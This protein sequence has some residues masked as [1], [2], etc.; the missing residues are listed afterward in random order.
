MPIE[1][2]QTPVG[3]QYEL[4]WEEFED[5][6]DRAR[7]FESRD[8]A[9]RYEATVKQVLAEYDGNAG[10]EFDAESPLAWEQLESCLIDLIE[11][12]W[13]GLLISETS[14]LPKPVGSLEWTAMTEGELHAKRAS[15]PQPKSEP[16]V[17]KPTLMRDPDDPDTRRM[18]LLLQ[19][20]GMAEA[21]DEP[22]DR[23][24]LAGQLEGGALTVRLELEQLDHKGLIWL[25]VDDIDDMVRLRDSGRQWLATKREWSQDILFFLPLYIDDLYAREALIVAG[26]VMV[27]E[28]RYQL[29]HHGGAVDYVRTWVVPH[30]FEQAVDESLALNLYSAAVALMARLSD[31]EPAGCVAEE[32]MAVH[33]IN[34]AASLLESAAIDEGGPLTAITA[35]EATRATGELNGIF[36]LFED[37]DVKALF[38]MKE[39]ADARRCGAQSDQ[40]CARSRGPAPAGVVPAVRPRHRDGLPARGL[41]DGLTRPRLESRRDLVR[42]R[43]R[44]VSDG[45]GSPRFAGSPSTHYA[46]TSRLR[47]C[48][49]ALAYPAAVDRPWTAGDAAS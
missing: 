24:A 11:T 4:T 44:T 20:V 40:P 8:K 19:A 31:E 38:D 32:I 10:S 33:L 35:E 42:G 9:E 41:L 15:K 46:A 25:D 49:G 28:F 29:L 39:P 2:V 18:T 13:P 30:A 48:T 17:P 12:W 23:E 3:L 5:G 47:S 43:R 26:T 1:E 21:A 7:R 14:L 37:D 27:D 6:P 16:P 36:E 22:I 45:R 34:E